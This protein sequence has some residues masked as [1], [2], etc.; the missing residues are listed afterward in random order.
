MMRML[1]ISH[2]PNHNIFGL[3]RSPSSRPEIAV[4]A[5]GRQQPF[6]LRITFRIIRF[7]IERL[8]LSGK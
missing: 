3:E 2:R 7:V 6:G 4:N 5:T 1:A 8:N